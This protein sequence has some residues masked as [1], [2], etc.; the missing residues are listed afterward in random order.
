[1]TTRKKQLK[2]KISEKRLKAWVTAGSPGENYGFG[3][4][5]TLN[6]ATNGKPKKQ[7]WLGQGAKV[8]SRMLGVYKELM[9]EQ[10]WLC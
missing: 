8:T 10:Q 4:N 5:W 7:L 2:K 1:M 3:S 6:I 9:V